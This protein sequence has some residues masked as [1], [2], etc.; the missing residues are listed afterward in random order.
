MQYDVNLTARA[1]REYQLAYEWYADRSPEA[2][3]KWFMGMQAALDSLKRNPER[4][5][6]ADEN[7]SFPIELRQLNFGS[8]RR[9]TH[10]IIFAIRPSTIVVY[11]IRHVAQEAW[12]PES[13]LGEAP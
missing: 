12:R 11:A 13:E 10:R 8:G 6:L 2:A 3:E 7:T 9:K 1:E 4:C 5:P